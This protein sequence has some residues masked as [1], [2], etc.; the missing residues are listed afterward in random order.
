MTDDLV[1]LDSGLDSLGIAILVTRHAK[2]VLGVCR[3]VLP[4]VQDAEDACQATFLVLSRK[5]AA[6]DWQAS[7]ANWLYGTARRIAARA[8][9]TTRR[10]AK[11]E[12]RPAPPDVP[13]AL[14]QMTGREA[15]AALDAELDRLPPI[16]RAPLVLC[17]LEGLTRE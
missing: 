17:H 8:N 7:V 13:S 11:R 12:T 10:R 1:L 15:F 16:Y 5:A 3:R 14:D 2:M 9:R 6:G 4:T